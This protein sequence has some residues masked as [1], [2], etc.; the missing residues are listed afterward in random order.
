MDDDGRS[1]YDKLKK[2]F[3]KSSLLYKLRNNF[4]YHYPTVVE[5]DKAFASIPADEEWEWYLSEANTNSF[6]FSC[7]LALGYGI[8][9]ATGEPL[10]IGA[11]GVVMQEVMQGAN[12]MP[13]FLMPLMKAV[14]NRYLGE[15]ILDPQPG[16]II[17]GAPQL[18]GFWIPFFAVTQPREAGNLQSIA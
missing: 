16:T 11:F 18:G 8:M 12:T 13:Y 4:L 2:Q 7:E 15:A 10:H 17:E 6:Y 5:L 3:G 14:L 9:N 1:S